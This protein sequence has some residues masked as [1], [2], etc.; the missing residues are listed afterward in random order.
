[1]TWIKDIK[2][3]I[4]NTDKYNKVEISGQGSEVKV[5]II[6]TATT[7]NSRV[8]VVDYLFEGTEEECKEYMD[9]L[10]RDLNGVNQMRAAYEH[11]KAEAKR[12]IDEGLNYPYIATDPGSVIIPLCEEEK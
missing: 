1:M 11:H 4:I 7:N 9:K 5:K 6:S 8:L 10:M 12:L 2:G 3:D